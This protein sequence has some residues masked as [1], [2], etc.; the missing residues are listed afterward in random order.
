MIIDV[1]IDLVKQ[2]G[3]WALMA[4]TDIEDAFHFIPIKPSD[5]HLISFIGRKSF[6]LIMFYQWEQAVQD[7]A[8]FLNLAVGISVPIATVRSSELLAKLELEDIDLILR[9]RRIRWFGHVEHS[10]RAVRKACGIQVED[11]SGGQGG[12]S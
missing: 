2:F 8:N 6:I 9:E 12:P 11:I 4:K 5:Y 3:P 10:S 1:V 7:L